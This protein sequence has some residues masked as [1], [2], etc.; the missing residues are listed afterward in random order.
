MGKYC[1]SCGMPLEK[2]P[3]SSGNEHYCSYCWADGRFTFEG[4][5]K[6]FRDWCY[7]GMVEGGMSR[8]TAWMYSRVGYLMGSMGRLPRWK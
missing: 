3:R 6:E 8:F 4:T 1:E 7:R 5:L 2:D